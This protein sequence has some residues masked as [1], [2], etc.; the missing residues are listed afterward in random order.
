MTHSSHGAYQS[1]GHRRA[2][3]AKRWTIVV[4]SIAVLGL[5]TAGVLNY[6]KIGPFSD[7]GDPVSFG[8]DQAAGSGGQAGGANGPQNPDSKV[9]MP[10]GPA[11]DFKNA[12]TLDNGTHVA[13]TTL[14]GKKSGFTGKV[15]VWAPPRST[16][17]RSSR[18]A[19]S[20]S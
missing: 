3:R 20:P 16:R 18:T 17:T 13:V 7:K 9:L 6:M 12:S 5:I 15:W 8:Q 4:A 11:A 10:T 14:E 2:S 1:Q 19:A